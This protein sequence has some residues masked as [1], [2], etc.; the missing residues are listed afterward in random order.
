MTFDIK[1]DGELQFDAFF[2]GLLQGRDLLSGK[3]LPDDERTQASWCQTSDQ[4][5]HSTGGV[6]YV[7]YVCL[8][9]DERMN[10]MW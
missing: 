7:I 9:C 3:F 2:H 8:L 6:I 1:V 4:Q 10:R 5:M